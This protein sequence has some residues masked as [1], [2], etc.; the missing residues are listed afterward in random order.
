MLA[1]PG[2]NLFRRGLGRTLDPPV[3]SLA[4]AGPDVR[5]RWILRMILAVEEGEDTPHVEGRRH[6]DAL[7]GEATV[8]DPRVG[9][10]EAVDER[11]GRGSV[12]QLARGIGGADLGFLG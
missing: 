9:S 7:G 4:Q 6:I 8:S 12:A 5:E 1:M 3:V 2:C 11:V 10:V